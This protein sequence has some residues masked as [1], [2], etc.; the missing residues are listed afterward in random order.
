MAVGGL[1]LLVLWINIATLPAFAGSLPRPLSGLR[2]TLVLTQK[3]NVF[4]PAPG[5]L[6]GWYVVRGETDDGTVVDVLRGFEGEPMFTRPLLSREYPTFRWR[7]Y[8]TRLAYETGPE[9]WQL[10]AQYLCRTWNE[11]KAAPNRLARLWIYFN[12]ERI[13]A[14]DRPRVTER[15]LLHSHHCTRDVPAVPEKPTNAL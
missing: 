13:R 9:H 10:Y 7:K 2:S 8:L 1:A 4:A 6:D 15:V 5:K 14:D 3:W 11:G 12:N